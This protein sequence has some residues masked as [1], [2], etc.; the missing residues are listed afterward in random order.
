MTDDNDIKA[1]KDIESAQEAIKKEFAIGESY[2][3][4]SE[5]MNYSQDGSQFRSQKDAEVKIATWAY[6][7]GLTDYK[8]FDRFMRR[9]AVSYYSKLSIKEKKVFFQGI[10]GIRE[11]DIDAQGSDGDARAEIVTYIHDLIVEHVTSLKEQNIIFKA[12]SMNERWATFVIAN[13]VM[14]T[15]YMQDVKV[16]RGPDGEDHLVINNGDIIIAAYFTDVIIHE[17][18]I[19]G[20]PDMARKVEFN[21]ASM[22]GGVFDA[23]G[24]FPS[25]LHIGPVSDKDAIMR[26]EQHGLILNANRA[27]DCFRSIMLAYIEAGKITRKEDAGCPGFYL[28]AEGKILT[29]GYKLRD[30]SVNELKMALETLD[31]VSK[32]MPKMKFGSFVKWSLVAPFFYALKQKG[33]YPRHYLMIGPTGTQKTTLARI[34]HALY[35][36]YDIQSHDYGFYISSGH[37]S[38]PYQLGKSLGVGTFPIQINEP[39]GLFEK[40]SLVEMLKDVTQNLIA[41]ETA[42]GIYPALAPLVITTNVTLSNSE[43][44]LASRFDIIRHSANEQIFPSE[45][46]KEEFEKFQNANYPRLEAIG[47][48]VA[49]KIISNPALLT[50]EYDKFG[51]ELLEEMYRYAG[52]PVPIFA[53][54]KVEIDT[55]QDVNQ[56]TKEQLRAFLLKSNIE[57]Y[58]HNVGRTGVLASNPKGEDY[59]QW[60]SNTN[61]SAEERLKIV[62]KNGFLPYQL[63]KNTKGNEQIILTT[64]LAKEVSRIVGEAYNLQSIGELLGFKGGIVRMGNST[65]RTLSVSLDAYI[66][67]LIPEFQEE[68]QKEL[69]AEPIVSIEKKKESIERPWKQSDTS[70]SDSAMRK[71]EDVTIDPHDIVLKML[72]NAT[73]NSSK[74]YK[75]LTEIWDPACNLSREQAHNFLGELVRKGTVLQEGD[76]YAARDVLK[77]GLA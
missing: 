37:V 13:P 49:A 60:D 27:M 59:P 24:H 29:S 61:V 51:T 75:T 70:K 34:S 76:R 23:S 66:A 42:D 54:S 20:I 33:I 77:G 72:I 62:I 21:A 15:I 68:D 38:S 32:K 58:S 56:S 67:F 14:E 65:Y 44:I 6:K 57:A 17:Q 64:A 47:Q 22:Y 4:P 40:D 45:H 12:L 2:H 1:N 55:V 43:D 41:R 71:N 53:Y 63:Y 11:S 36:L 25:Y 50:S 3:D 31:K 16:V 8:K 28:D 46:E 18:R 35:G 30:V 5:W 19:P 74:K 48:Y 52:M 39:K 10:T 26:L 69:L 9:S 7:Y 73:Y